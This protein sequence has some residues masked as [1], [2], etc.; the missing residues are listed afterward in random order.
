MKKVAASALLF[1]TCVLACGK[2]DTGSSPQ[3]SGDT[4][5]SIEQEAV[6]NGVSIRYGGQYT[7][8]GDF[9]YSNRA[10]TD[11]TISY[12]G[13]GSTDGELQAA[14]KVLRK[15]YAAVAAY[16]S[17]GDYDRKQRLDIIDSAM[18]SLQ[19]KRNDLI[20]KKTCTVSG[21]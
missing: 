7:Y 15:Y 12:G 14:I 17:L 1:L 9:K 6:Q 16:P 3:V 8:Y 20:N 4:L 21:S 18:N 19:S 11:L 13:V 5:T 10:Y 2:N